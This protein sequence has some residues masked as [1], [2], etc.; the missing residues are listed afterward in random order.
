MEERQ[1]TR[2]RFQLGLRTV[3]EAVTLLAIAL[4]WLYAQERQGRVVDDNDGRYQLQSYQERAVAPSGNSID[5]D[6]DG[7]IHLL[8]LDTRTGECWIRSRTRGTWEP[9]TGSL[10]KD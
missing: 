1:T 2:P 4:A 3:F 7:R 9:F 5:G 10:P 6:W 8:L